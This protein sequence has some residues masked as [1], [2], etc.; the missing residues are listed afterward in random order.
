MA[1]KMTKKAP[2]INNLDCI[3]DK[4]SRSS[5]LSNEILTSFFIQFLAD[6]KHQ[7]VQK[8]GDNNCVNN[9]GQNN[10]A[11]VKRNIK[12]SSCHKMNHVHKKTIQQICKS[13]QYQRQCN[14]S[15]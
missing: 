15:S 13:D 1:N 4:S 6:K 10:S 5:V 2:T 3:K 12:S 9:F 7:S 8:Y 11:K 14:I